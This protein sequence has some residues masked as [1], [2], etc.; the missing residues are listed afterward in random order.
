M[1]FMLYYIGKNIIRIF[2]MIELI[3]D[4]QIYCNSSFLRKFNTL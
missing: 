2:R 4:I 1:A 3:K